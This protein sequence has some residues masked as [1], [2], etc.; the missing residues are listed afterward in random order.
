MK[1]KILKLLILEWLQLLS[2]A[3]YWRQVVGMIENMYS[4]SNY[5]FKKIFYF[6]LFIFDLYIF[7]KYFY[8]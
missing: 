3:L 7:N 5:F 8:Y 6:I 2:Q 4:Q 1:T